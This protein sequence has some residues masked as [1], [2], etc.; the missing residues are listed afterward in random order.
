M[1]GGCSFSREYRVSG[2]APES[3]PS[4]GTGKLIAPQYIATAVHISGDLEM[5]SQFFLSAGPSLFANKWRGLNGVKYQSKGI[6]I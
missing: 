6:I 2:V 4:V 1:N 3:R 5:E